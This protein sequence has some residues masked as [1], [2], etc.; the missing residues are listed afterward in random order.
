MKLRFYFLWILLSLT[1]LSFGQEE[2]S[3]SVGDFDFTILPDSSSVK[4]MACDGT[5][6]GDIVIP[7]TANYK[8]NIYNVT[9]ITSLG[10][11]PAVTSV[12]IP[13]LVSSIGSDAFNNLTGNLNFLVNSEN[14]YFYSRNGLLISSA[15][16]LIAY[17]RGQTE[18]DIPEGVKTIRI[19]FYSGVIKIKIPSSV[20]LIEKS[21]Y[22]PF[23]NCSTLQSI[24][25]ADEN[26]KYKSVN[27]ILTSKDGKTLIGYPVGNSS[28][29][30]IPETV[31]SIVFY[32]ITKTCSLILS[33]AAPPALNG[34]SSNYYVYVKSEDIDLYKSANGWRNLDIYGYDFIADSTLYARSSENEVTL[35][36]SLKQSQ[37][38]II[39]ETAKDDNGK[40]YSVTGIGDMAYYN[41]TMTDITIP[42]CIKTIGSW[43][44]ADC[45]YL[46]YVYAEGAPA[47]IKNNSFAYGYYKTLYV[48]SDQ[49]GE[50]Q[51]ADYWKNMNIMASDYTEGGLSYVKTSANTVAVS[52]CLEIRNDW[53]I[54]DE[55]TINGIKYTV[56]SIG[57]N[58][59]SNSGV[60]TIKL[61]SNLTDIGNNAFRYCNIEEITLPE[62]L[63]SIGS[64]AFYGCYNLKSL[65]LPASL[66]SIGNYAF[67]WLNN[68]HCIVLKQ[69]KPISLESSQAFPSGM[70]FIVIPVSALTAYKTDAIWKDMNVIGA[71]ALVDNLCYKKLNGN[72]VAVVGSTN[73]YNPYENGSLTIPENILISGANYTVTTIA[74]SAFYN[75]LPRNTNLPATVDSIGKFALYYQS[76]ET[77]FHVKNKVPAAINEDTFWG[78]EGWNGTG[79]S[80]Q[81]YAQV[82]V[83]PDALEAYKVAKVWKEMMNLTAYDAIIDSIGYTIFSN[84]KV[85][86]SKVFTTDSY[87]AVEIPQ[88]VTINEKNYS[89]A[90]I[91]EGAFNEA[92]AAYL[93]LPESIDSIADTYSGDFSIVYLKA[94]TPPILANGNYHT[95]YVPTASLGA[96][97]ENELWTNGGYDET[98]IKGSD[99]ILMSDSVVYNIH[100]DS[101]TADLCLWKKSDRDVIEV[102]STLITEEG[103]S[104]TITTL[105]RSAFYSQIAMTFKIPAT[106]T[107]I[108]EYAFPTP[109]TNEMSVFADATTPPAIGYQS[110]TGRMRL[111]VKSAA[112]QSY[113]TAD[114]WKDFMKITALDESD[115]VFLYAKT[116]ATT[117][118][119]IGIVDKTM[120]N[121]V[122][123][124]SATIDGTKLNITEIAAN[125][126]EGCQADTISLPLGIETIGN[127]AFFDS[128]SLRVVNIPN[129]TK[130]IGDRAFY[131][132]NLSSIT[133]P[134]SL[135]RIGEKAL[136]ANSLN[137]IQVRAGNESYK[138]ISN[139]LLSKDGKTLI[140]ASRYGFNGYSS[141]NGKRVST[142]TGVEAIMSGAFERISTSDMYLPAS[143]KE[144][145][146]EVLAGI[147]SIRNIY[148]DEDNPNY[149]SIDGIVFSSDTTKIIYFPYYKAQYSDF[150]DY[151]LPEE[152]KII[153]KYA[154]SG[155]KLN[156]LTIS[157]NL[158][159]IEDN[160]FVPYFYDNGRNSS[161]S[162]TSSIILATETPPTANEAAFVKSG[163]YDY[164]RMYS[165]T[166]LYVP[167]GTLDTYSSTKPWSNFLKLN[168]SKLEDEDFQ[169]LKAF[170]NEMDN[171]KGWYYTW[172]FGETAEETKM[173][174]GMRMK[175]GHV[176]S[177]NL[178]S[179]G[180]TGPLSNKLFLLPAIES[181]DFSNNNLTGDIDST[182]NAESINC[183]TL[184]S[185]NISNN[186]MTG[187]IGIIGTTMPNLTTL[188]VSYN[189][190]SDVTPV[191]PSKI[192]NLNTNSQNIDKVIDYQAL[193]GLTTE[194]MLKEI[195]TI[196]IYNHTSRTYNI[197]KKFVATDQNTQKSVSTTISSYGVFLQPYNKNYLYNLPNGTTMSLYDSQA[198]HS[199]KLK[200]S[201]NMGDVDFSNVVDI[202]D[203]Q[204]TVDYAVEK[205]LTELFNFTAADIQT[206]EWVNVQDVVSLVNIII[207]Q[208]ITNNVTNGARNRA[209]MNDA[210]ATLYW[211]DNQLVLRT[212]CEISA[213]DIAIAGAKDLRWLLNDADYDYN[214]SRKDGYIRVIHYSMAGK[215]IKPGET[216][217]A[218]AN[219]AVGILKAD[220]IDLNAKFVKT[221]IMGEST[222]IEDNTSSEDVIM[223]ADANGVVISTTKDLRK[224]DWMIYSISGALLGKGT[225]D[226]SA[227][228]NTLDCNLAGETQVIVR[229]SGDIINST[230]KISVTK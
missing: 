186:K 92:Q 224:T 210:E 200:I 136:A 43:S 165:N 197:A 61:P 123:P 80:K 207:D 228:S 211:R 193:T 1:S 89:V 216:V 2:T 112:F 73:S 100:S 11:N 82:I 192:N 21:P 158:T 115:G 166:T 195:P 206:D 32:G 202:A 90:I 164:T 215:T 24:E 153:G 128:P 49:V 182:L 31:D 151:E 97:Q 163:G 95:I 34:W 77:V 174:R 225:T 29:A 60:M 62:T 70:K 175:D 143:L 28:A 221:S 203:L 135:E 88:S 144:I 42:A 36:K 124:E 81:Y 41:A 18:I 161:T 13:K 205:P 227:G 132:C 39:P 75:N 98:I 56:T 217:L 53:L 102:P 46:R 78:Y 126:F 170:Y 179:Y 93:V 37:P 185:L 33:N 168:S 55:V 190:F 152:V 167:M 118:K 110:S 198:G 218:V 108:G 212:D 3:F 101:S 187:N 183:K 162:Y 177:L 222:G 106:I 138:A 201:F 66:E 65:D 4:V 134:A 30:I 79:Y 25:V 229:L 22:S 178:S 69:N 220:L 146:G 160:A 12:S 44:F 133:I 154:F 52:K 68:I 16:S 74:D 99:G 64:Y 114:I 137:T 14:E 6:T 223:A 103:K 76:S 159:A 140:Q 122:I 155:A 180:L 85:A 117:A 51:A 194:E 58:A 48:P 171:G 204:K 83:E 141:V 184:T 86:V 91:G 26:Q 120:K 188:N 191:L 196:L 27:G 50:Y 150:K 156:S 38:T 119:V 127:R 20:E 189:K 226:L 67:S 109:R 142:M 157:E 219:G 63:K 40:E 173:M 104:Y 45:S 87:K 176:S 116:S 15:N 139:H 148:I 17:P 59:F 213:M 5:L 57:E 147:N 230:M 149:C 145:D 113:S 9:T 96:Y 107:S 10:N 19:Q 111:Y 84:E 214:I 208:D 8:G 47:T 54:P 125:A 131:Y 35:V 129:T 94:T 71:D 130:V 169:I 181:L 209:M 121:V 7:E 23:R 105:N 199:A 72:T 172:T